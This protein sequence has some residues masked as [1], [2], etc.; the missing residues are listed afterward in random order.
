MTTRC[1]RAIIWQLRKTAL[2]LESQICQ[3][4]EPIGMPKSDP[5]YWLA[6]IAFAAA[7]I[8]ELRKLAYLN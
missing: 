8:A 1:P 4:C 5:D 6:R 7:S 2:A 3:Q